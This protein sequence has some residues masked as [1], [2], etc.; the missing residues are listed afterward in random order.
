MFGGQWQFATDSSIF[1]NHNPVEYL[2]TFLL[3]TRVTDKAKFL[4]VDILMYA[5]NAFGG[6]M[7]FQDILS[8][9]KAGWK[10]LQHNL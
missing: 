6:S 5:M 8:S 4:W 9:Y 10:G 2:V 7:F 1:F 3:L